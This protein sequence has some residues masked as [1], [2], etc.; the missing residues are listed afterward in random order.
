MIIPDYQ[1]HHSYVTDLDVCLLDTKFPVLGG[2]D[3]LIPGKS[4]VL[5]NKL[6]ASGT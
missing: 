5:V 1:D 2:A 6:L 3:G 4:A